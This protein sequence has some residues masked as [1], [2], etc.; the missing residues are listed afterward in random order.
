MVMKK[1][2]VEFVTRCSFILCISLILG[3]A[4]SPV[5]EELLLNGTINAAQNVV[6][7]GFSTPS[8][9]G[10]SASALSLGVFLVGKLI[11]KKMAKNKQ[12]ARIS[13]GDD[14]EQT[15]DLASSFRKE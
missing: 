15:V 2:F 9:I 5:E 10:F 3:C 4:F 14:S 8:L 13:E 7:S 6:S 12:M 11:K 1:I